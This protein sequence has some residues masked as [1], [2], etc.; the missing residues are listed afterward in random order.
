AARL[1]GVFL[2]FP[3]TRPHA[4]NACGR[5]LA[6]AIIAVIDHGDVVFDRQLLVAKLLDRRIVN[7]LPHLGVA[8]RPVL[9]SIVIFG[10]CHYRIALV[11]RFYLHFLV[12]KL[13]FG[14]AFLETLSRVFAQTGNRVSQPGVP[15]QEFGN[16]AQ[17]SALSAR[18][19][20]T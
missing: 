14:N 3:A 7:S 18:S 9:N 13:L 15:K 10:E 5:R 1:D 19:S 8:A 11:S 2:I 17:I 20:P 6:T 16:E 4:A 12:P